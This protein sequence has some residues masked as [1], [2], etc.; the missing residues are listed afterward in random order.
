MSTEGK[1]DIK[2]EPSSYWVECD[3]DK[4]AVDRYALGLDSCFSLSFR[5]HR[6]AVGL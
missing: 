6:C 3:N 1:P 2:L 5:W 4:V